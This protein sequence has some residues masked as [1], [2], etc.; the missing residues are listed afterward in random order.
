YA[1]AFSTPR[2]ENNVITGNIARGFGGGGIALWTSNT[3]HLRIVDNNILS[4]NHST[5]DGGGFYIRYDF[6]SLRNNTIVNNTAGA[7]GGGV[8][9]LNFG[10]DDFPSLASAIVWGNTAPRGGSIHI[11]TDTTA[12]AVSYSDIEG[13]WP[14]IGMID[15][16]PQFADA[17]YHLDSASLCIDRGDPDSARD[18]LC[19]PP[20]Q[21][22]ARNDMGA[23]GG[24]LACDWP[25]QDPAAVQEGGFVKATLFAFNRPNPF[26]SMTTL[27]L[28]LP[29]DGEASVEI[30]DLRGRMVRRLMDG[31]RLPAGSHRLAWDGLAGNGAPVPS[32]I[33]FYR[34]V[35]GIYQGEGRMI[36]LR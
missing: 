32:G 22:S 7:S 10:G 8:Y 31:K 19:F 35:A 24:P 2:I 33:Y 18:D 25:V 13:G 11:Y 36:L 34:I 23:Y 17:G 12:F 28:E 30:Y 5:S 1:G 20:S 14:G 27:Q 4:E 6:S 29:R 21:G 9:V 3:L 16:D 26:D 15:D